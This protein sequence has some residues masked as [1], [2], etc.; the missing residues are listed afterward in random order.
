[1]EEEEEEE[2]ETEKDEK[3]E[4]TEKEL[5][6]DITS[7]KNVFA[8][9]ENDGKQTNM[10]TSVKIEI[11]KKDKKESKAKVEDNKIISDVL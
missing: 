6:S 1:M 10:G 8:Q 2:I 5:D 11:S 3:D 4:N 7:V 9:N